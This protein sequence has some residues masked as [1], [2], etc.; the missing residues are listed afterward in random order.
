MAPGIHDRVRG[1]RGETGVSGRA[2]AERAGPRDPAAREELSFL[3]DLGRA[4]TARARTRLGTADA[5]HGGRGSPVDPGAERA[6]EETVMERLARFTSLPVVSG[7]ADPRPPGTIGRECWVVGPAARARGRFFGTGDLPVQVAR[8]GTRGPELALVALPVRGSMYL[9]RR[10]GGAWSLDATSWAPPRRLP[11]EPVS[12]SMALA[13]DG[14][15]ERE[16]RMCVTLN[17]LPTVSPGSAGSALMAVVTGEVAAAAG[18]G[19]DARLGD[20]A[21]PALIV[22]EA[23]GSVTDARGAPLPYPAGPLGGRRGSWLASRAVPHSLLVRAHLGA[24]PAG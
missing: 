11:A 16:R 18:P 20:L 4:A 24:S 3:V 6:V 2:A 7:T 14:F 1:E 17:L 8:I 5:C 21:A 12:P 19:V 10:N 23:G 9:A 22:R 13:G 15:G